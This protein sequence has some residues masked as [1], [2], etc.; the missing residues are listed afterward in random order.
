MSGLPFVGASARETNVR[1]LSLLANPFFRI[2]QRPCR[3]PPFHALR[4]EARAAIH[5]GVLVHSACCLLGV[6]RHVSSVVQSA[7]AQLA[8]LV[9]EKVDRALA[10]HEELTQ[11]LSQE[12]NDAA[13]F[14][15]L[16]KELS[17]LESLKDIA[18]RYRRNQKEREDLQTMI[19]HG[20]TVGEAE[21]ELQ[22]LASEELELVEAKSQS[23]YERLLTL[24]LPVDEADDR[25]VVLEVRAG[26]GG[27]EAA[28]FAKEVFS[29]YERYSAL[30]GWKFTRL[31]VSDR[32]SSASISCASY[33]SFDNEGRGSISN[34]VYGTLK[35][36]SGVHRVQ[37]VPETEAGGRVHTSTVSVAVL[38]EATA[39]DVEIKESELRVETMRASGAG[40][41]HVNTT[42]SAV[43]IT[44][45]PTG[46]V[47][48]CQDERSQHK[49]KAKAMK[50]L[51]ARLFDMERAKVQRQRSEERK[52]QIGTGDRSERI[53]TYNFPQ[54]RVTD[55]RVGVTVHGIQGIL[56]GSELNTL[57]ASLASKQRSELIASLT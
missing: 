19:H 15:A 13:T 42:D 46:V 32:E 31:G 10:R 29:M 52:G 2:L 51:M 6:A 8:R 43:R 45:I 24:L 30:R 35:F 56:D 40:G 54:G 22:E 53:R 12:G 50:V 44:H 20:G 16:T 33:S 3:A 55:H 14:A 27:D 7:D 23:L 21:Q 25:S 57:I 41:Q 11:Q 39:V 36:E 5:P 48:T 4:N 37:R 9:E 1:S 47:V 26:A 17:S 34:G 18:F 38:P 49:N 28:L